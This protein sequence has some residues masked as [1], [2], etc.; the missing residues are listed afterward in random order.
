MFLSSNLNKHNPEYFNWQHSPYCLPK[1][2]YKRNSYF[3]Y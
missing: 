1:V 3:C 2:Q